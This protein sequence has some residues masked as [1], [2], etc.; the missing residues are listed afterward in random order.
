MDDFDHRIIGKELDLFHF[1]EH[2]PGV[3]FWH[4]KGW[5]IYQAIE[6]YMRSIYKKTGFKEIKTPTII[7]KELW[8]KSGHWDKYKENM[9]VTETEK[10]E[11]AI[12]PMNCP[13]HILTF[14]QGIKSY[15]DLPIRYGEFGHCHRNESSG[16]MHGLLRVRG[17]V[18]DD[19]HIFCTKD[20]IKKEL[21]TFIHTAQEVYTHFG[22][23]G[24]I[25]YKVST[26]PVARIGAE[27]LW[28]I[29][30][31]YL[32][33]SL[34]EENLEYEI[35]E[36][37]GAFYG[38]KLE[39]TLVDIMGR[40]WQCGTIQVDFNLTTRLD[41]SYID[42]NGEKQTPVLLHRAII[43]SFERFIG[44]LLEEQ[45]GK[46][47]FWLSPI[48]IQI[49]PVSEKAS[50]YANSIFSTLEDNNYRVGID[51]ST[52]TLS[53][54]IKSATEQKIPMCIIVG[55]RDIQNNTVSIRINSKNTTIDL[56]TLISY[57]KNGI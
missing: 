45:K 56:S 50:A 6:Q 35:E 51:E 47:P 21:T 16:S 22:F 11:Y 37:G 25:L 43:G 44:I 42:S 40:K 20:Q 17:F 57:I 8:E 48:Q 14:N 1:E 19:G 23:A 38:P 52:N 5:T 4:P 13:A 3:V 36:G 7:N 30:E 18:Q 12:K 32:K 2:S 34:S 46:L 28:D 41:S 26:R 31:E 15:K 55:E 39:L 27:E 53:S 33:Q 29:A 10:R 9:F 49:L 54:R 24:K